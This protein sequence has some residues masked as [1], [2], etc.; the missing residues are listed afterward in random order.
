MFGYIFFFQNKKGV[1]FVNSLGSLAFACVVLRIP[2][3]TCT[4]STDSPKHKRKI[5]RKFA[6]AIK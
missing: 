5:K 3:G 6:Y 1:E 2:E 4:T